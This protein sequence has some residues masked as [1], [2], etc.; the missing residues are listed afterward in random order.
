MKAPPSAYSKA[1]AGAVAA[2]A[3][4]IAGTFPNS[5]LGK[6]CVVVGAVLAALGLVGATKNTHVVETGPETGP[7]TIGTVVSRTGQTVGAVVADT[8]AATGGIVKG[9]TGVLGAVLDATVGKILP[10]GHG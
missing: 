5:A 2:A 3:A 8:G 4:A 10:G 6:W 7:A 1:F 9:T